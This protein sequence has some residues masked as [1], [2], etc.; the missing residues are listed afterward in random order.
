MGPDWGLGDW[1]QLV[2]KGV[3]KGGARLVADG[4]LLLV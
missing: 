2:R 4:H 3:V 1:A